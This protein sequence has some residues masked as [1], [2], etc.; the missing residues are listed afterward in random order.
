MADVNRGS[1]P[2]SP[3]LEI[4]R[5]QMNSIMSILHR[6]T[7]VAMFG[8]AFLIVWWLIAAASSPEYFAVADWWMTSLLGELILILSAFALWYHFANGI[9]HLFWDMGYGFGLDTLEK[10][11]YAV[12]AVAAGLTLLT[13]IIA[14]VN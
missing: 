6:I 2:L 4:Y 13:L 5:P 7:G 3:H 11:G 10:S 14:W 1:R 9:R 12:W 8:S